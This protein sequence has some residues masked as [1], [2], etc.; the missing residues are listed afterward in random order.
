MALTKSDIIERVAKTTDLPKTT[1]QTV[2]D[3]ALE[4]IDT[5]THNGHPV[6]FKGFGRFQVKERAARTGRNPRTGE[7][8]EIAASRSL[9]FKASKAKT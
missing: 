6:V 3:A 7:P 9:T 2:L 8:V 1:V 5:A 4:S